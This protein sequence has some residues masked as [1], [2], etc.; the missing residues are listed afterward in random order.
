MGG[1]MDRMFQVIV[2]GGI[3][4]ATNACGGDV[5]TSADGGGSDTGNTD[6]FPSELPTT[7]DSGYDGFPSELP[8]MIDAGPGQDAAPDQ[9]AGPS[10]A[11]PDGFPSELPVR[12][13]SG[14][15]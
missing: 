15:G 1:V 10:D 11:A 5:S 7:I 12:P 14:Q 4:L 6:G 2:V 8:G 13:D 9:D 3:A